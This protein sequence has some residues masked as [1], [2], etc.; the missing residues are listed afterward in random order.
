MFLLRLHEISGGCE[1]IVPV[2]DSTS[3]RDWKYLSAFY[4]TNLFLFSRHHI[5][6][7]SVASI[8]AYKPHTTNNSSNRSDEGLT[9]ETSAFSL[10]TVA[11]HY[12]LLFGVGTENEGHCET[13]ISRN[14]FCGDLA[15]LFHIILFLVRKFYGHYLNGSPTTRTGTTRQTR[16][17]DLKKT[18]ANLDRQWNSKNREINFILWSVWFAVLFAYGVR[19]ETSTKTQAFLWNILSP[20]DQDKDLMNGLYVE[21]H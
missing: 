17:P 18:M 2:S 10:L 14:S 1:K 5:P 3:L 11:T 15:W 9:L 16:I 7:N 4:S 12:D 8:S 13:G 21:S 19:F 6:T 20:D